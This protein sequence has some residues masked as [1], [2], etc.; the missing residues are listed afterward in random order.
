MLIDDCMLPDK[1]DKVRNSDFP[2][3]L[4]YEWVK[5]DL[6]N[7]RQFKILLQHVGK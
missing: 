4:I 1:I 7:L 6:I 5:K 3:K 2:L